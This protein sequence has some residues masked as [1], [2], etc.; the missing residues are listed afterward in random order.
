[1]SY[2]ISIHYLLLIFIFV[3]PN[4]I[5]IESQL[6]FFFFNG[7]NIIRCS[8]NQ[9]QIYEQDDESKY[10]LT[11]I[12]NCDNGA[13][14][15]DSGY[16]GFVWDK[17]KIICSSASNQVH[18]ELHVKRMFE[19]H[20]VKNTLPDAEGQ[21]G[22]SK[23]SYELQV[24]SDDDGENTV[25]ES[26][27][28]PANDLYFKGRTIYIWFPGHP[29]ICQIKF[30]GE[31]SNSC[32]SGTEQ[33]I[34]DVNYACFYNPGADEEPTVE[35]MIAEFKQVDEAEKPDDKKAYV[36]DLEKPVCIYFN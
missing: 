31:E 13:E 12:L 6:K 35:E 21:L 30:K 34:E 36:L 8:D 1:M 24:T 32:S 17:L 16:V 10:L 3:I 26:K 15:F 22:Q 14:I 20:K 25:I 29:I 5:T 2:I 9:V 19:G 23:K 4:S 27:D 11:K 28:Q 7:F 18:E 33:E